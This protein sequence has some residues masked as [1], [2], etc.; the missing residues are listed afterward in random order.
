MTETYRD[1]FQDPTR[2]QD[3]AERQ[4]APGK[5]SDLLWRIEQSALD[6]VVSRMRTDHAR[7]EHLDFACGT[8]RVVGHLA[9]QVDGSSGID[10]AAPMLEYA[11]KAAPS[12]TIVHGDL[13]TDESLT[14]G[15]F[16]LVTAFRFILNAEPG[17]RVRAMR[18]LVA[19]LRDDSSLIVFNNHGNPWSHKALL[20]PVHAL[21]RKGKG[22]LSEGNYMTHAQVMQLA[23]EAGLRIISRYGYGH[24]GAKALRLLPFKAALGLDRMLAGV[25]DLQRLGVNQ[26]YVAK[27]A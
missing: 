8:G 6:R 14:P 20:W 11:R 24:V 9:G 1:Q 3:Y 25:W 15:P 2:A 19:R 4:Y 7:I 10:I 16:D 22:Y 12:A 26:L 23:E 17:L 13:T 21:R 18:A 5:Y 27:K